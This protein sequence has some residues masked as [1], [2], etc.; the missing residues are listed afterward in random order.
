MLLER[1]GV[2]VPRA[3][4]QMGGLQ[5]QYAG[6]GYVGLWSRLHDFEPPALT[7]A[8]E[9]RTVVQATLMRVTIHLVSAPDYWPLALAVREARRANYLRV[10]KTDPLEVER[11]AERV[12]KLLMGGPMRRDEL[13]KATGVNN[14]VWYGVGLWLDLVRIPPSGTWQRKRADLFTTAEQ[15]LGPPQG[16]ADAGMDLLVCRYLRAFGPASA[17]EIGSWGGV[18]PSRVIAA[19]GRISTVTYRDQAG[20]ELFDL[21][22]APLPGADTPAPVRFLPVW[23]A[24]LLVHARRSEI[25]AEPYRPLVFSVKTPHSVGTFLVDGAVAGTWKVLKGRVVPEPFRALSRAGRNAVADEAERLSAF[26]A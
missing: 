26:H 10:F 7:T 5:N 23:D 3:L 15:W 1:A 24:A 6:S 18:H 16:D 13:Q 14:Q 2:S 9:K 4:E 22:G 11:L 21:P 8:L 12:R 19:F 20:L 17:K 25:L